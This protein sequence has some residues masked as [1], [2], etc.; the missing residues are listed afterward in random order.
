MILTLEN[1]KVKISNPSKIFWPEEKISKLDLINFYTEIAPFIL[2]YLEGRPESLF[3]T[4]DGIKGLGFFQKDTS[5]LNLPDW[6]ETK[7]VSKMEN[8]LTKYLIINDLASLIYVVNLGCIEIN[9][10][11]S[12]GPD[13]EK[14]DYLILDL[15]PVESS[16]DNVIKTALIIKEILDDLN[17]EGY[18]KTSGKRGLHIY[19]PTGAKYDYAQIKTLAEIIAN[20][21]HRKAADFTSLERSP[22]KR[23]GKVYLDWLQNGLDKTT[24][25]P[26]SVRPAIKATVSVPLD[27]EEIRSGLNPEDFNLKTVTARLKKKGDLFSSILYSTGFDLKKVLKKIS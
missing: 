16:F 9:P 3:R 10:W 1:K 19:L 23:K 21:A 25:A 6:I 15:D 22:K 27:W 14:P 5:N 13:F 17:I 12:K 8:S 24:V 18:P 26:Y 2:P 20:L 11:A 7:T 4:P